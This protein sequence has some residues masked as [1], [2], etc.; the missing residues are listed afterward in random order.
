[1]CNAENENVWLLVGKY[2][3][4]SMTLEVESIFLREKI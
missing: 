4:E 1:M 2:E 3:K